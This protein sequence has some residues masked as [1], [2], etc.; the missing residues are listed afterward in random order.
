MLVLVVTMHRHSARAL[1]T[2]QSRPWGKRVEDLAATHAA[3]IDN[4][5]CACTGQHIAYVEAL[6]CVGA[7]GPAARL[8]NVRHAKTAYNMSKG[9]C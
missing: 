6:G 8:F 3:T 9:D 5:T 1:A 4:Q 7:L 2:P